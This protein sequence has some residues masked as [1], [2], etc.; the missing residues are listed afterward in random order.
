MCRDT[1]GDTTGK[2]VGYAVDDEE[3]KHWQLE[4]EWL[5][6]LSPTARAMMLNDYNAGL[7]V[8][9]QDLGGVAMR[10]LQKRPPHLFESLTHR[11]S[12]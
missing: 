9:G 1:F 10:P 8:S 11:P 12:Y 2:G 4:A 5:A 7:A 3:M 6:Q